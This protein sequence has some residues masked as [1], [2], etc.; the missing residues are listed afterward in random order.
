M[1][2]NAFVG[3]QIFSYVGRALARCRFM[4]IFAKTAGAPQAA[5]LRNPPVT[6]NRPVTLCLSFSF[7][8][9]YF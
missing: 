3:P 6:Y 2:R 9:Q 1:R 5:A 8:I 7:I 4:G